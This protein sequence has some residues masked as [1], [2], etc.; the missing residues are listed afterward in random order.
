[1]KKEK[2][3]KNKPTLAASVVANERQR[4]HDMS[5]TVLNA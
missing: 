5:E 3:R 4:T 2:E 1:M